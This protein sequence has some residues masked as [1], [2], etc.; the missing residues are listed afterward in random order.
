[1]RIS[2]R[3]LTGRSLPAPIRS[4]YRLPDFRW[5]TTAYCLPLCCLAFAK[6][7]CRPV[8]SSLRQSGAVSSSDWLTPAFASDR[9]SHYPPRRHARGSSV[10]CACGWSVETLAYPREQRSR[11]LPGGGADLASID[12][13]WCCAPWRWCGSTPACRKRRVPHLDQIVATRLTKSAFDADARA[14]GV[15][16]RGLD[17]FHEKLVAL[18][19]LPVGSWGSV[20]SL[21]SRSC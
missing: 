1:M 12:R 20:Y 14:L 9:G 5:S 15:A 2:S 6:Q 7:E 19:A 11:R 4:P 18:A 3:R 16:D 10:A 13:G 17:A 21:M 8:P